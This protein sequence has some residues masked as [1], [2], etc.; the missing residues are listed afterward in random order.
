[1]FVRK[2]PDMENELEML[3][4]LNESRRR[5][6]EQMEPLMQS[7]TDTRSLVMGLYSFIEKNEVQ[8]KLKAYEEQF[9]GEGDAVKERE[10]AQI[11]R[12]VMDLLDSFVELIGDEPVKMDEFSQILEAGFQE[13]QVGTIPRNVDRVVAGDMERTRLKQVK[14]LFFL[15]V[16]DGYIPKAAG[17]GGIISDMDREF[18]A[19]S[20][21]ELAPTPR[22]QMYIQKLYLYM[23]M[24]K[25]SDT[26]YLSYARMSS[27][28]RS[29]RPAYLIDTVKKLFPSIRVEKP[30]ELPKLV[31]VQTLEDGRDGFVQGLRRFADGRMERGGEDEQNFRHLYQIYAGAEKTRE[32]AGN[33][34]D[35]AFYSYRDRP[36]AREA[37][38]ALFGRTLL[39]S[40]SRL[41]Q[42]ASC[43]YAHFLQYGLMLK[44]RDGYSFEDVDM[45]NIFHGVLEIFGDKLKEHG[46]NWFDFP[47]EE[48]ER[49]VEE[50]VEAYAVTYGEAVLFDNARN[51]YVI[52]RLKRILK[53]TVA[54][55]QYQLKKGAFRPEQFEVSFSVLED[56]ESVNIALTGEEKLR[57]R[58]RID[59][60]DVCEEEEKVYVKVIDYKS[61]NRDFS[62][63]A[64]YY[65]LQLQLVV[66]MN[67]A[68]EMEEKRYP[69][70]LVVPAAMLYYRVH[71]PIVEGDETLDEEQIREKILAGLR[72][73]GVVNADEAV[74]ASLD[75]AFGT[76]SDVIPVERKKDGSF[77]ARSS[78]LQENDFR[79]I[80]DYVNLKIKEIGKG[81][82]DGNIALNPY[83]QGSGQSAKDACTYC[84]YSRVCGFDRK[85]P[86]FRKRELEKLEEEEALEKIKKAL[87]GAGN[88]S[89]IY[90][91][92]AGDH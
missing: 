92:S 87:E 6:V 51:Q 18:L 7:F 19:E 17:S 52:T 78:I 47:K 8:R 14:A 5:L 31:Q 64:L 58:G 28:G 22:Q 56:L 38:L 32:W 41:E 62:L 3:E 89:D 60:V 70:R 81:I 43:A 10:Y 42:Y 83:V 65:G 59:R 23:N 46:W 44:E 29:M 90:T 37:A 2:T 82:L 53:R 13:I 91:G 63:A 25:P 74:V 72:M 40:V 49:L 48:G 16:N 85:I 75:G 84:P 21:M 4:E 11:Y 35:K 76:K 1:M 61:G 45:G 20:G 68:V 9:A 30:E 27:E 26:L 71:D 34:S 54:T 12:L 24:T 15:G 77:S 33:M 73:T 36:L 79:V 39:G 55:L 50:A 57:L 66:Y 88:G 80:S 67:A 86:G 69:D